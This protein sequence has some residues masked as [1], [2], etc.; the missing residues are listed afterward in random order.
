V[1]AG[2]ALPSAGTGQELVLPLTVVN[3]CDL[4]FILEDKPFYG[5]EELDGPAVHA[6]S[7]KLSSVLKGQS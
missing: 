7:W 2:P 5:T 1:I 6:R 4:I 3:L